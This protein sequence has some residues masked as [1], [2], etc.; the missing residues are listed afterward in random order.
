M[1][2]PA[3]AFL[4]PKNDLKNLVSPCTCPQGLFRPQKMTLKIWCLHARARR[5]FFV[6]QKRPFPKS[7]SKPYELDERGMEKSK[8]HRTGASV[9]SP[10][11]VKHIC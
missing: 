11:T 1:Q 7:V 6:P 8:K 9:E 3:G 10:S 5:G 2:V 4:Y